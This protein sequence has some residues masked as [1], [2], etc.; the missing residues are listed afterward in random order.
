[1]AFYLN[2]TAKKSPNLGQ[3]WIRKGQVK[4]QGIINFIF[5]QLSILKKINPGFNY[6]NKPYC[7]K[8][9][10]KSLLDSAIQK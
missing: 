6:I 9:Y 7:V 2:N 5:N 3:S 10:L 1:M 8:A 4:F